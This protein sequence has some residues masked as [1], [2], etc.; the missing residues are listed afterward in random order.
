MSSQLIPGVSLKN[1]T[2]KSFSIEYDAINSKN[3]FTNGDVINGR[4]IVEA[5]KTTVISSL[6]F[7]AQGRAWVSWGEH[8]G[9]HHEQ[10]FWQKEKYY[11]VK[12]HMFGETRQ[13]GNVFKQ[14]NQ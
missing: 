4:I 8:C 5:L 9:P 11:D 6:I 3:T 1:M 12:H 14:H 2:I 10:T 7:K 13:D